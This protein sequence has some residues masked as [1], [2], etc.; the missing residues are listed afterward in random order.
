MDKAILTKPEAKRRERLLKWFAPNEIDDFALYAIPLTTYDKNNKFWV[1]QLF[2]LCCKRGEF[3][4]KLERQ[5][6]TRNQ[7]MTRAQKRYPV[8]FSWGLN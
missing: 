3:I 1:W 5:G 7:A 2:R 8:Y 4:A 6:K